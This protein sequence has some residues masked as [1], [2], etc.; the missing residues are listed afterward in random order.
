MCEHCKASFVPLAGEFICSIA[1]IFERPGITLTRTNTFA[2]AALFLR[3]LLYFVGFQRKDMP[4]ANGARQA[5]GE[6]G[7]NDGIVSEIRFKRLSGDAQEVAMATTAAGTDTPQLPALLL[8]RINCETPS[9]RLEFRVG[10]SSGHS[11]RCNSA[12]AHRCYRTLYCVPHRPRRSHRSSAAQ[13]RFLLRWGAA[14][15]RLHRR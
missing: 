12:Q 11:A 7:S 4:G 3:V 6:G 5:S 8:L 9:F 10:S 13:S 14:V 1:T 2:F 15:V